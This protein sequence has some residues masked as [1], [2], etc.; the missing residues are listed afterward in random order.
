MKSSFSSK[1]S[2][3][4]TSFLGRLDQTP[5]KTS[6][7]L[8]HITYDFHERNLSIAANGLVCPD[9]Y[10]VFAHS[11]LYKFKYTFPYFLDI[12]DIFF[13]AD[14]LMKGYE[15]SLYS[16]WRIDTRLANVAW[17]QDPNML[18]DAIGFSKP[19]YYVCTNNNIPN[20]ALKLFKFDLSRYSSQRP[21]I[22]SGDGVASVRPYRND[23]DSLVSDRSINDYIDWRVKNIQAC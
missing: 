11:N 12:D 14:D 20:K 10:A 23:F 22:T 15:F 7:Y 8:W 4:K 17:F 6:R 13:G 2:P 1:N 9:N 16:F 5:I 21:F 19:S 18:E 3:L